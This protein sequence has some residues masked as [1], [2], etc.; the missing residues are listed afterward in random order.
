MEEVGEVGG[1][2]NAGGLVGNHRHEPMTA[3]LGTHVLDDVASNLILGD[4]TSPEALALL[5]EEAVQ[6]LILQGAIDL[7][8][9]VADG[10][11][12]ELSCGEKFPVAVV[13]EGKKDAVV[14]LRS[15]LEGREI[16]HDEVLAGDALGGLV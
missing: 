1:V 14:A 10:R 8:H 5:C 4:Q 15:L 9:R 7:I 6:S 13:S 12:L 2:T 3:I 16:G 11:E